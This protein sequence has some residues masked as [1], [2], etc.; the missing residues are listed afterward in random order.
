VARPHYEAIEA[1]CKEAGLPFYIVLA[2]DRPTWK[3]PENKFRKHKIIQLKSV[4]TFGLFDGKAFTRK[5]TEAE[6]LDAA[7][8]SIVYE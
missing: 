2:G 6:L 3:N 7:N 4:P 1:E 8:R 5:L